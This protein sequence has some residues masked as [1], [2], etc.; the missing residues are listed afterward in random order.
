MVA[1]KNIQHGKL[2]EHLANLD[3]CLVVGMG[4]CSGVHDWARRIMRYE[5]TGKLIAPH[6]SIRMSPARWP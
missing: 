3:S 1:S 5:L 6:L 4:A 2:L